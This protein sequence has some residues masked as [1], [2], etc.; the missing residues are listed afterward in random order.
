MNSL[1]QNLC[2]SCG[3]CC[4]GTLF[5]HAFLD[6]DK[7]EP[8]ETG[9]QFRV[10]NL[11]DQQKAFRLPCCYL[12][13]K[14]CTIYQDR[15]YSVCAAFKCTLLRWVESDA[16]SFEAALEITTETIRQKEQVESELTLHFPDLPGGSFFE[17]V[18]AFKGLHEDAADP[19]AFRQKYGQLLLKVIA[20]SKRFQDFY[21][22]KPKKPAH[23]S[24]LAHKSLFAT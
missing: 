4:N 2:T 3:M 13:D 16:I 22:G 1:D 14:T 5:S 6:M 20:L 12:Q 9:F 10:F 24:T 18:S 8:D 7:G 19:V 17:K 21:S 15:P 23:P 11:N